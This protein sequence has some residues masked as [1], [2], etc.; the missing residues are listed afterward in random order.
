MIHWGPDFDRLECEL[1]AVPAGHPIYDERVTQWRT[2]LEEHGELPPVLVMETGWLVNGHHRLLVA[3]EC[4]L[5]LW[6]LIVERDGENWVATGSF[7]KV[8]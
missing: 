3:R 1:F 5:S 8:K 7:A 2:Y 4:G 6:G